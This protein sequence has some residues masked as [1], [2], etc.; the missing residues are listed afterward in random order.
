MYVPFLLL[1]LIYQIPVPTF[2][3]VIIR[4]YTTCVRHSHN[5]PDLRTVLRYWDL[6]WTNITITCRM[7]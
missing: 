6:Y 2:H 7:H 4:K 3:I 1:N 5:P